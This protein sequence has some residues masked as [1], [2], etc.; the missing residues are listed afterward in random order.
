M[1]MTAAAPPKRATMPI[2]PVSIGRHA[3]PEELLEA[4][5]DALASALEA[6]GAIV[7]VGVGTPEVNGSLVALVAPGKASIVVLVLGVAVVLP[8]L[9]S[10]SM[11]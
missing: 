5:C 10:L 9:R 2:A 8:G 7:D 1:F 11:T 6:S 3:P 4:A